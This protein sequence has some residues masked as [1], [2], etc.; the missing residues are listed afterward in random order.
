VVEEGRDWVW[1]VRYLE[2]EEEEVEEEP[3][4][5]PGRTHHNHHLLVK[6]K[7]MHQYISNN[8][9]KTGRSNASKKLQKSEIAIATVAEC[10]NLNS[11]SR[12]TNGRN[13]CSSFVG[14][15]P[16]DPPSRVSSCSS[17][18]SNLGVRKARKMFKR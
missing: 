9:Q 4:K 3:Q 10:Q 6:K 2:E 15:I 8:G 18:G 16:A 7:R 17:E 1:L 13:S 11:G 14:R 5:R 12:R